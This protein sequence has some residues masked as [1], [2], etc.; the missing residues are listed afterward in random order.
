MDRSEL[1][2]KSRKE[3]QSEFIKANVARMVNLVTH[4]SVQL[5]VKY[6]AI[7]VEA[8]DVVWWMFSIRSW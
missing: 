6:F 8:F 3:K 1:Q 4:C 2:S 7:T 5:N